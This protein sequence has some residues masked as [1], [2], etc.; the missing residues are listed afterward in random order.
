MRLRGPRFSAWPPL[1]PDVYLRSAG[2]SLPFPLGRPDARVFARGRAALWHGLRALGLTPGDG[3]LAPAYHHGSEIEVF[4][5]LGLRWRFYRTHETLEPDEAHLESL[6]SPEVRAVHLIHY[7][8]FPQDGERWRRWCD[9]RGLLLIEDAAMAWLADTGGTPVGSHGDLAIY[10]LYKTFGLPDGAALVS[11]RPPDA[12][13]AGGA[14]GIAGVAHRHAAWLGQRSP[15]AALLSR[16]SGV[17]NGDQS[18]DPMEDFALGDPDVAPSAATRFLLP[19]ISDKAA[20]A[21]R[22]AHHALLLEAFGD[23]VPEPFARIPAGASPFAFPVATENKR[24][25]LERLRER[26]VDALDFWS[27]PH[28][29]LPVDE[30][31]AVRRRRAVTVCL[32]VHQELGL[33]DLEFIASAARPARR[34]SVKLRLQFADDLDAVSDEW[35]MLAS[36]SGNVFGTWEWA[37]V[38]WRHFGHE[39]QLLL[40]VARRP[41]GESVAVVPLCAANDGRLRVVRFVGHGLADQLGPVHREG[42][43]VAAARGVRDTLGLLPIRW[44]LF[45]GEH[46]PVDSGWA[47][48]LAGRVRGREASPALRIEA[49]DWDAFLATL[50]GHFRKRIRYQERRLEREYALSFRLAADPERL[51]DDFDE[52]CRLHALRWTES[53]AFAGRNREFLRDFAH[54]ALRRGWLRLWFMELDGQPVAAWLGFRLEGVESYY[55]G[56]RDPAWADRSVGAVLMIHSL[57]EAV[58]DGAREYRFLRGDEG[59]K[60]RLATHDQGL[61]TVILSGSAAGRASLAASDVRRLAGRGRHVSRRLKRAAAGSS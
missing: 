1:P 59:Y 35:R 19:R 53:I 60:G 31:P 6:L 15:A 4:A 11:R 23:V 45:V 8:G 24:A 49:D 29:S 52:L 9:E 58:N 5:R 37:S 16:G 42:D 55:Q 12:G 13:T 28:P 57:R 38:W 25:L 2:D 40:S 27:A 14:N 54:R 61:E 3:V 18:Y 33:A 22:R 48:L 10:C 44:D 7:L 56:G 34:R 47:A 43:E 26:G 41:D 21:R 20:A 50:S 39:N 51:D 32:P 30:F 46:L 36:G 17:L